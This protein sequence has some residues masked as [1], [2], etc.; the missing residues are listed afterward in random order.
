METNLVTEA[1]RGYCEET[2]PRVTTRQRKKTPLPAVALVF[3]TETTID[4]AQRLTFGG[5]AL[6]ERDGKNEWYRDEPAERGLFFADGPDVPS[7]IATRVR[8][9]A[10]AIDQRLVVHSHTDFLELFYELAYKQHALVVAFNMPFDISRV[11]REAGLARG[12]AKGG[13]SFVMW[14]KATKSGAIVHDAMGNML[15]RPFRPRI[16]VKS[17]GPNKASIRFTHARTI[18]EADDVVL[19][20]R[21]KASRIEHGYVRAPWDT[22]SEKNLGFNDRAAREWLAVPKDRRKD[23]EEA[24]RKDY[25]EKHGWFAGRFLDVAVLVKAL[26]DTTHSLESACKAYGAK[27]KGVPQDGHPGWNFEADYVR[28]NLN[29]VASTGELLN[30]ALREYA[31][32]P[33]DLEPDRAFSSASI[34]KAYL[35]AMGITPPLERSPDFPRDMLGI[36]QAAFFG[37]RTNIGIRRAIVPV[38]YTDFLSMYPTAN[39]LLGTINI[40]RA[41]SMTVVDV[42]DDVRTFLASIAYED[43]FDP[44]TWKRLAFFARI[45]RDGTGV[46][47]VRAT[48]AKGDAPNIG[49]VHVEGEAAWYAG[50]DILAS[51]VMT[52]TRPRI[53]QALRVEPARKPD[54]SVAMLEALR[55]ID[56]MGAASIDPRTDDVF[57]RIIE[58]RQIVRADETLSDDERERVQKGLKVLANGTGY[59]IY[60]ESNV[61]DEN[62]PVD[63]RVHCGEE[64]FEMLTDAPELPGLFSFPPISSLITAGAHLMLALLEAEVRER[65]GTSVLEDTDSMAIVATRDGGVVPCPNGFEDW[66]RPDG[67]RGPHADENRG[68]RALSFAHVDAIVARFKPL[69]PY[70]RKIVKESILKV[71]DINYGPG[72]VQR[73]LY[74]Y[75]VS[76]KRYALFELHEDGSPCL[77]FTL[78]NGTTKSQY[79]ESG[80]GAIANPIAGQ[81]GKAWIK[82]FWHVI[83]CRELGIPSAQPQWF[84]SP[85]VARMPVSSP[86]TWEAFDLYNASRSYDERVKPFGFGLTAR[87]ERGPFGSSGPANVG[88]RDW[89]NHI[90][91]TATLIRNEFLA[92][93]DPY[94]LALARVGGTIVPA[95]LEGRERSEYVDVLRRYKRRDRALPDGTLDLYVQ[96][97]QTELP[98]ATEDDA[99]KFLRNSKTTLT[100]V[101]A[102]KRA[103]KKLRAFAPVPGRERNVNPRLFAP[104]CA[105]ETWL[106]QDDASPWF[107]THTGARVDV[108]VP[109]DIIVHTDSF[110]SHEIRVRLVDFA[111]LADVHIK[112]PEPKGLCSDGSPCDDLARTYRGPLVRRAVRVATEADIVGKESQHFEDGVA[113]ALGELVADTDG[114]LRGVF[115]SAPQVVR[116]L[117]EGMSSRDVARKARTPDAQ[118]DAVR[119]GNAPASSPAVNRIGRALKEIANELSA[120]PPRRAAIL[121]LG[122]KRRRAE[123][124]RVTDESLA[125]L[126]VAEAPYFEALE[127]AG[128][129]IVPDLHRVR[130]RWRVGSEFE[131]LAP[132]LCRRTTPP[133]SGHLV[134]GNLDAIVA[135]LRAH[136]LPSSRAS[137]LAWFRTHARPASRAAARTQATAIVADAWVQRLAE[138]LG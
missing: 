98:G 65:G 91:A 72:D 39:A 11:A 45:E 8:L 73:Q 17:L 10:N 25:V 80:L 55:P 113:T 56:F 127:R 32:H 103:E 26:T 36:A 70:D 79:T 28:Y 132:S 49:M 88:D 71:E 21:K 20:V 119:A 5:Y 111:N 27:P 117:L 102:R 123:Y 96:A 77:D 67:Y 121:A 15:N 108:V 66:K 54:G 135:D 4:A 124:D 110:V 99:L 106:A 59:G 94:R 14:P 41:K 53:V 57:S 44:Q 38:V 63:V 19:S 22:M 83:V 24:I 62:Q 93:F 58:Q 43:A 89:K 29:D 126:R 87:R 60:A 12:N 81:K 86:K 61:S 114:D 7:N 18:P 122:R 78:A 118:V 64:S 92:Q 136:G 90:E 68:I 133:E 23:V 107:D 74:A 47:P 6:Y 131:G 130:G 84:T 9:L 34:G 31:R 128:G 76:S 40:L 97:L 101:E 95:T 75:A 112:H 120:S 104:L 138:A 125:A 51:F 134:R 137:V 82:D 109:A 85:V 105:P 116:V 129:R 46:L 33:I 69:S 42:T 35:R 50:P 100:W 1:I 48:F 37:G 16:T 52:G 13:F 30:T 115:R 2:K 3:D